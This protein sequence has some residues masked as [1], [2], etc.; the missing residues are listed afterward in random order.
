MPCLWPIGVSIRVGFSSVERV[1]FLDEFRSKNYM[2]ESSK[3]A[4]ST[5]FCR[6]HAAA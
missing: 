6:F 1:V 2:Y 5:Q 4:S 3:G